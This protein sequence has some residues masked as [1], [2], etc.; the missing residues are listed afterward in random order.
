MIFR[1]NKEGF[2][3]IEMTIVIGIL[4]IMAMIAYPNINNITNDAQQTVSDLNKKTIRQASIMG[5]ALDTSVIN[6]SS[7]DI[8]SV[9]DLQDITVSY[10][11]SDNLYLLTSTDGSTWYSYR[12]ELNISKSQVLAGKSKIAVNISEKKDVVDKGLTKTLFNDLTT[13]DWNN[14]FVNNDTIGF[15]Y[16]TEDSSGNNTTLEN[17]SE[18]SIE[19]VGS[20]S[21]KSASFSGKTN[22]TNSKLKIENNTIYINDNKIDSYDEIIYISQKQGNDSN[23]DGSKNNPF[24]SI[25]KGIEKLDNSNQALYIGN[26]IYTNPELTNKP[27]SYNGREYSLFSTE[28]NGNYDVIGNPNDPPV[29]E[30][31][32][33][34]NNTSYFMTLKS[35]FATKD[36][37]IDFYNLKIKNILLFSDIA[38]NVTHKISFNNVAFVNNKF[39]AF[40][41]EPYIL[42]MNKGN[43]NTANYE[44]SFNNSIL[45]ADCLEY[46]NGGYS[47]I[48]IKNSVLYYNQQSIYSYSTDVIKTT[49]QINPSYSFNENFEFETGNWKDAG[50]GYDPDGSIADLG[51]YGGPYSW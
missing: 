35:G 16:Y 30:F 38:N 43:F 34:P 33:L 5:N 14:L 9:G 2:T 26:G 22:D 44:L 40:E 24:A 15:A 32:N 4:A 41:N 11:G 20:N 6:S 48:N 46:T 3:L 18:V 39:S 45:K 42:Y 47:E 19:V 27:A 28:S 37:N 17:S 51:V 31:D 13:T 23:G 36:L 7:V 10:T 12:D 49:S 25:R 21:S 50:T 8:S 1:K 29:I